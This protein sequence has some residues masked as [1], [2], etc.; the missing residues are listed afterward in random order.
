MLL[1]LVTARAP[2]APSEVYVVINISCYNHATVEH[3][4]G[5]FQRIGLGI[6]SRGSTLLVVPL[7][8]Q[9]GC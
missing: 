9:A 2:L 4:L 3:Y 6:G 8:L 7:R 1:L 5:T